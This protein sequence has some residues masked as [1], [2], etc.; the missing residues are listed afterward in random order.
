MVNIVW[1][2]TY[3]AIPENDQTAS[4]TNEKTAGRKLERIS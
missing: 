4:P 3:Q 2:N 1:R